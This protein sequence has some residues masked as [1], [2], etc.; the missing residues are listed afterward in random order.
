MESKE[1]PGR[2][3]SWPVIHHKLC[4]QV[5]R[6]SLCVNCYV[7][8]CAIHKFELYTNDSKLFPALSSWPSLRALNL[9][10]NWKGEEK[11]AEGS[12]LLGRHGR[13]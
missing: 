12:A 1:E 13:F 4:I 9:T 8:S 11:E 6:Y 2:S 10:L 5:F 7:L 3:H